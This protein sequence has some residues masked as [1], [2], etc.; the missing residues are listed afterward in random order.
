MLEPVAN[1][2]AQSLTNWENTIKAFLDSRSDCRGTTLRDLKTR[3]RRVLVRPKHGHY[4]LA[5]AQ[6]Q[7]LISLKST[8]GK[9]S[10]NYCERYNPHKTNHLVTQST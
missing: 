7:H 4:A 3:M 8:G 10:Q 5:P 9:E 1:D 6:F 2:Q